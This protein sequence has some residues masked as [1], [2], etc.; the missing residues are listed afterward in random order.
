MQTH[1]QPKPFWKGLSLGILLMFLVSLIPFHQSS[2]AH[3]QN[4]LTDFEQA[5]TSVVENTR[6]AVVTVGNY[7]HIGQDAGF[8]PYGGTRS[9]GLDLRDFETE[10]TM[11]GMGSGVIYKIENDEA[12]VVT[13]HHVVSEAD[14]VEVVMA[15]GQQVTAEVVGSDALSD[16]AVLKISSEGVDQVIEFAQPADIRVGTLAL[17]V[18][19]PLDSE[20]SSSVTQG[21]ISGLDRNIEVDTTGDGSADWEMTLIQ[22]DAAINQGNSGGALLNSQGQLIGI[23]SAKLAAHGVEGMGFA[24]PVDEVEKVVSQLEESGEVVRPALS[25]SMYPL[26]EITVESREEILKLPEEQTEGALIMEVMPGSVA[27]KAGLQAY[28]VIIKMAGEDISDMQ[29]VKKILY[30]HEIGEQID[31][32]VLREGEEVTVQ[33]TLEESIQHHSIQ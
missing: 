6:N 9:G 20:Y 4:S 31:I 28:D 1:K 10:P 12:Y 3:S 18:G 8:F 25:I 15:D 16:L 26:H 7:Q 17:A 5:V 13:N 14:K 19:S 2:V 27:E 30:G 24:I 11:V 23:N 21:I 22:T 32:T 33:A 29:D